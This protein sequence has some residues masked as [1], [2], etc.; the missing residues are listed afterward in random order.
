MLIYLLQSYQY[1]YVEATND[2]HFSPA[3]DPRSV[4]NISTVQKVY[5]KESLKDL[6]SME[7]LRSHRL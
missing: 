6:Y 2:V 5:G 1:D 4:E 3:V 7:M